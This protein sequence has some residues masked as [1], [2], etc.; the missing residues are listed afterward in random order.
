MVPILGGNNLVGDCFSE[1][2]DITIIKSPQL[3]FLSYFVLGA[4]VYYTV[5]D[6]G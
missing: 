6:A 1:S 2:G 3:V 5:C 4:S